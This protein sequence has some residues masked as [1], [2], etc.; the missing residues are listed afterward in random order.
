MDL[1]N[2]KGNGITDFLRENREA[3]ESKL[4]EEPNVREKI[5]EI[6]VIGDI[7]LLENAHKLI[8]MVVEE[9]GSKKFLSTKKP[10]NPRQNQG[11]PAS[12]ELFWLRL[13]AADEQTC[14][15]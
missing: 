15:K 7:N 2:S 5:E 12:F 4:L 3:F 14:E 6:R 9:L 11:F 1:Y 10:A 13:N 8:L